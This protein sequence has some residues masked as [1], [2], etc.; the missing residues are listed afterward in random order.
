MKI[1]KALILYRLEQIIIVVAHLVLLRWIF[2]ALY[3]AGDLLAK[4]MMI[5]FLGMAIYG[6]V[7]IR[8]CAFLAKKRHLK[9]ID[10]QESFE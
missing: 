2:F 3:Q 4:D 5:H 1:S 8:L 7:L 10:E 9:Q 6:A